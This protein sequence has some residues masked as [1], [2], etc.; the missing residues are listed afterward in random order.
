MR[1][2][3]LLPHDPRWHDEFVR[4]SAAVAAAL[5]DLH[6]T[7]HHI[8][9]T[10][11][12]GI[13]AKPVIDMIPVVH[14]VAEVD[15]RNA[16][17][18]ALGYEPMGEFGIAGRRFFRKDNASGE[19]SHHLHVFPTGSPQISRHLAFRDFLRAHAE[20]AAQYE[21]LKLRLAELHPTDIAAYCEGKDA[22]IKEMDARA[23][24]WSEARPA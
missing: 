5:G 9:S 4:E 18:R 23:K 6:V 17:L 12:P 21:A 19:R 2:V 3:Y 8:G 16:A 24:A 10:A 15:A 22:F 20:Y 13:A 7:I 1:R 14:D 11:I